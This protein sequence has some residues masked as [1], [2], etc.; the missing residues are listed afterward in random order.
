MP[1]S[2]LYVG[3]AHRPLSVTWQDDSGAALDLTTATLTVRFSGVAGS[4]GFNGTGTFNIT[5]AATGKF[6]YTLSA[7][8]VAVAGT[9]NLQFIATYGDGTKQFS[10]PVPLSIAVDLP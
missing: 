2:P 5:S 8:D 9:W 1:I 10:D 6:T 7:T 3:E 4:T